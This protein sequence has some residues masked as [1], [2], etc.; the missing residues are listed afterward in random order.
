QKARLKELLS[1]LA[2]PVKD[3]APPAKD[4]QDPSKNKSAPSRG[5]TGRRDKQ[6]CL[7]LR[8]RGQTRLLVP[9]VRSGWTDHLQKCLQDLREPGS[10]VTSPARVVFSFQAG[11]SS[12]DPENSCRDVRE[13]PTLA[14]Y[15]WEAEL[16]AA[17]IAPTLPRDRQVGNLPP[18]FR[19]RQGVS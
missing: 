3:K 2:D 8:K 5:Q 10:S 13:W 14:S 15:L 7:S 1:G 18:H 6:P 19:S 9:T 11:Q 4:K 17:E 12:I 16:R